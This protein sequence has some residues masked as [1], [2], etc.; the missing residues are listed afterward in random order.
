MMYDHSFASYCRAPHVDR[1][2]SPSSSHELD[3]SMS[4]LTD[5]ELLC[6]YTSKKCTNVRTTK[7]GG[8]LHRFCEFHRRR[9]NENQ[10]RVDNKRRVVRA[11]RR[12]LL[13]RARVEMAAS[14]ATAIELEPLNKPNSVVL[15]PDDLALL[16]AMLFDDDGPSSSSKTCSRPN[17]FDW[18]SPTQV[19]CLALSFGCW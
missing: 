12:Q 18:E 14:I 2:A 17:A 15:T 3:E 16:E 1:T 8:G 10:W 6:A 11:Q 5:V 19:D 9:A 7:K 13:K 4:M